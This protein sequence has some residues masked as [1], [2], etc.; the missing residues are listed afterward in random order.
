IIIVNVIPS[1]H[2]DE[3]PV[4]E[5]NQNDDV[6]IV[7]EPVLVDEDEDP[8]EDEFEEEEDPQEEDDMEIKIEEDENELE[9][10][11]P[12]EEMD[13]LNP[14]LPAFE[15][16]PDDEIKVENPIKYED[17]TVPAS[18]Y[19]TVHALVKKKGKAKDKFYGQ[20]ILELGNKVRSSVEQGT[21]AMEK[22]VEKLGNT[23]DKV[24]CKKLKKELEEV[25]GFLFEE[26]PNEAINVPI[27]DE[28]SPLFEPIMP[29]KSAPM[30]QAVIRRMIKDSVDVA[31]AAE[32]ARQSNV[33][34]DASG[35][36]LAMGAVELQRWFKK[37]ESVFEISE[38]VEGKKVKFVV[39]TLEGPALTW[40]K[41]K[42]KE[43][44]V[45]AYT[46]R[47][48]ELAL[49]CSRMVEPERVK[50]DAYIHGL[51][52][53]IKGEVTSS[54]PADLNEAER[55]AHKLME[56]KLQ[57]RDARTLEGKKQKNRCPKKVK[58]EEVREA[59][60]RAYAIKDAEPQGLNVVTG[61]FLLNNRYVF[62]LFDLGSD[63][64]FVD[65][66][67]SAMLDIDPIKIGA[68][69][70]V[71][72]A[73]RRLASTNTVLKGCTLNLCKPYFKID[74]MPIEL[75]T[76]DVIIGM[77]WLVKHDAVIVCGEKVVRIPYGNEM[78]I[79]AS[80][81][82]VSRLK[83]ISCIKALLRAA[84][85]ARAPYR[86]ALSEMKEFLV[87]L[88]ELMEKVFIRPSSSSWGAPVLFV[89]KK[90]GSF[91]MCIDYRELNKLTVKNRY[92]L[93]RI[94]DLLD[95]Q[96]GHV[97]D[98]SG[99]HVD[100]AK[101]EAIKSWVAPTTPTEKLCSAPIL[102][103]PEGT[104][105]SV[106]YCDASLKGY[107]AV[108]MQREKV[109]TYAFRQLKVHEENFTTHD[110]E[111]G[112]V[113]FALKL[114]RNYLYG[115][116][117]VVFTDHKSLQYILN[118]KELNLRQRRWI[119][120]QSDYDCEI[121][122][123]HGKANVVAD[124]LS[125]KER[126][127]P[128]RNYVRKENLGR[129]IKRY[130][131]FA[132]MKRV[133]LEIIQDVP[134]FKAVI[135]V[136]EYEADI[137]TY[138]SKCLT[139]AK[140]KVEHRKPSGLLQQPEI[141]VWKWERITMDFMSG[142]PR[143][144]SG[145]LQEALGT[146]LDMS[147]AYHPQTD[148]QSE[149]TIQ[150]LED[151]LRA[152]VIDFGSSW[153]RHLPLVEFAYNNCYHASIKAAP[154]KALYGRK[155][156]SHVCWR[157]VG[158]SQL[159]GPELIRDTTEKIVHIKNRLLAARSRQKS[160]ADKR[161]KPLEFKVGDMVLLKVSSWK[162]AVHFGKSGKL[163]PH[164]IGSFKILARV[165]PVAYTLELPEELKEI[166]STFHVSNLKKCLAKDDVVIPI[167]E[168]QLDDKLH[169]IEELVEV[170]DRDVKRLK[171]SR[172]PIV[173]VT[174]AEG[175]DGVAVSCVVERVGS[176]VILNGDSLAPT[177]VVEGVLQP[178][179]P[180]TT[181]QKLA[182]K[183]ELK[184]R[185]TLLTDL[186]DKHQ[187]RFNSHK[188]AKTLMEAIEK[189]F[190]GNTETKKV[191]KTLLKQQYENFTEDSYSH[192][193]NK[194]DLEE[195]SLDD[196]F[197]SLK[198]YEAEVKSSFSAGTSTQNLAFVSSSNTDSTN[199]LVS[200][201]VSVSAVSA[202]MHVFS[203]PNVDTLSNVAIYSFFTSQSNS[204]RLDNDD[205]K[206]IDVDDLEEMNL[207]WQ[208]A[209]W[210][211]TTATGRNTLQ[212]SV[213]LLKIQKRNGATEP[214]RRNVPV[215]T[216]TS[217]AL[218]FQCD[219]QDMDDLKLKLEKFQTSSKNLTEL[220]AS[221]TNAKTCLGYNSQVFTRAM[222]DC[223]GYLSSGSDESLPPS[224]IY[225]RYQSGN[226]YLVV[227]P[228][229]T[230]TFVPPKPNLV[231]N[232]IPNDVET[233]HPAFNVK[234]GPLKPDNACLTPIGP[235]HLS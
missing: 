114:W 6:F 42:V 181:E 142:F 126:I 35:S 57:A 118:Q 200:V 91:R 212:G 59:R 153:D 220:L 150:T 182:K 179:A 143:T 24:E 194:T 202:K 166:H 64:S 136:A 95:Q 29:P 128:L 152:C 56:Q 101:I 146:N 162:G 113:V 10:A 180:T 235:R 39:A 84:P 58:Q 134:R 226:G 69:Y 87:Q 197:N 222:F 48:N 99:V 163:S 62:V 103:L 122:Y 82:G 51:T 112:S 158:D 3:V 92:P 93:L 169:I 205:L 13:P 34:N 215:E 36:G 85:V 86:L 77:D 130:S 227:P 43:Y 210:S 127:K 81:K 232:T 224:P 22:L 192:L 83:V 189:R 116:K 190:R 228:P 137:A 66:R 149:R 40:W 193:E 178:V 117:C 28:K 186:P 27:E 26:R 31:I 161:I 204:P 21:A 135:L 123:H 141:P 89:K 44:D 229:Y 15:P 60:G 177:R 154:Y 8:E 67:F 173:K 105:D 203:L 25:K 106:V 233:D 37:T 4:V 88:Q 46:Q 104:E 53:N 50:V 124:A 121:R 234:L 172:I 65:T 156:R 187:L 140:V 185:G 206:Q 171:K 5:P 160:Y 12:Y 199:E 211:V 11:Y 96:Q 201:V 184:V 165:G 72:L 33:R 176:E 45:V 107:G 138:V 1:D 14:L 231:F 174:K 225:D 167:D 90:D 76:F 119:E 195:Q 63:R 32:R 70:K 2:V 218:V 125:W 208:M 223:D 155:C 97:I 102:A 139:C 144:L 41:T 52:D 20:L 38:C 7:P 164:Y 191:Q 73:D 213:G 17:K 196:L 115:T 111:L 207:K 209:M 54:K 148:G 219:E 75:G 94:D 170:V 159:T 109:I 131:S 49:T 221:Q 98:R 30:T 19:E 74:L 214:Q 217:N 145:S 198:I 132:L 168:I 79:V 110:L 147:T 175:N 188:D 100:L 23:E 16:E 68:S 9:M 80:N 108:L 55:M 133:V 71:E 216:S 129:L 61:T 157:E 47:F 230:G 18:V 120:L 78:L 183:N 151:M